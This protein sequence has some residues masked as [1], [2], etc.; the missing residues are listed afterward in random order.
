VSGSTEHVSRTTTLTRHLI[1]AVREHLAAR[2]ELVELATWAPELGATQI[3]HEA[4]P[5]IERALS[6]IET[7]DLLIAATPVHR[8]SYAGFFK[9]LFDLIAQDSLAE[10]PVIVA[11]AG[12]SSKHS[13]VIDQ[14]L[15]QL[16]A[17]FQA[18]TVPTGV[19]ATED[20]FEGTALKSPGVRSRAAI[21]AHQ[22]A[23]IVRRRSVSSN[24]PH[25]SEIQPS[26]E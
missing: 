7:A 5:R 23:R 22:A 17:F 10:V 8:G 3:R 26:Q 24:P 1:G 19:Y 16:F 4:P 12:G 9:H 13:L 20:D 2:V 25:V 14:H 6:L 15:R 21:A 18:F 11:A